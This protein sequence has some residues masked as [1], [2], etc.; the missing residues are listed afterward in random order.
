M[1]LLLLLLVLVLLVL[2]V[3]VPLVL[4]VLVLLV[5]LL[6]EVG[7][8]SVERPWQCLHGQRLGQ[9][10]CLGAGKEARQGCQ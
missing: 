2:L 9:W 10:R 4:L 5:L 8:G 1:L 7:K 3:L 6:V